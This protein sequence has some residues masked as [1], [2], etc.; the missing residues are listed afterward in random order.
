M[1]TITINNKIFTIYSRYG[2]TYNV[3]LGSIN[4]FDSADYGATM[5]LDDTLDFIRSY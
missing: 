2:R 1:E 3:Y 5:S 4:I